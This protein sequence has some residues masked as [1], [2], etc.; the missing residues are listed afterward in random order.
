[1]DLRFT[2]APG[3]GLVA[4]KWSRCGADELEKRL[5]AMQGQGTVA[6]GE[7]RLGMAGS[8]AKANGQAPI[9]GAM[10]PRLLVATMAR[11]LWLAGSGRDTVPTELRL[12]RFGQKGWKC[13]A[14][15]GSWAIDAEARS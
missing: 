10:E 14:G 9:C 15:V 8:N 3:L 1:M 7:I 2:Q 6:G 12:P 5:V 4:E 13:R 11:R